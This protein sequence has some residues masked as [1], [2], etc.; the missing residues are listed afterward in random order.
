M[1]SV[2]WYNRA[3]PGVHTGGRETAGGNISLCLLG[4][5][6]EESCS[7]AQEG[8]RGVSY[9]LVEGYGLTE[10][11]QQVLGVAEVAVSTA[12]SSSV[13]QLLHQG[14]V[15]P[16]RNQGRTSMSHSPAGDTARKTC[17]ERKE[18]QPWRRHF[19]PKALGHR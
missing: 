16:E 13:P 2:S 9:L 12:L 1:L 6:E 15:P 8:S 19:S 3:D 14:Q 10:V 11:A 5:G 18:S 7:Q 17:T 4:C